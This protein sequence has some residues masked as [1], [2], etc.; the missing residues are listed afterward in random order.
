MYFAKN[1]QA[2]EGKPQYIT[3]C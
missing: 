1:A 2:L 3:D